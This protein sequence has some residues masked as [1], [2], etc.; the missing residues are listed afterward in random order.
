MLTELK[1]K[2]YDLLAQLEYLQ[3]QLQEVNQQIAE[4]IKKNE[5]TSN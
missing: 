1:A 5:D 4:E 2:A 3:K